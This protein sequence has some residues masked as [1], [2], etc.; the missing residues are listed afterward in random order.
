L[1]QLSTPLLVWEVF[2]LFCPLVWLFLHI[3]NVSASDVSNVSTVL[4]R[5]P[6]C[7]SQLEVHNMYV[8]NIRAHF[9]VL[10]F[11]DQIK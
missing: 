1:L 4:Y 10:N 11:K 8:S 7:Q 6:T 5:L 2:R 9:E 3:T